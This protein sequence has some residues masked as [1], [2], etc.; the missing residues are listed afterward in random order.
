MHV[1]H[2][3]QYKMT[4]RSCSPSVTALQLQSHNQSVLI[5]KSYRA[6]SHIFSVLQEHIFCHQHQQVSQEQQLLLR[7]NMTAQNNAAN[8]AYELA[9]K[10]ARDL[11]QKLQMN[12]LDSDKKSQLVDIKTMGASL[13]ELA[14]Q[15]ADFQFSNINGN[16]NDLVTDTDPRPAVTYQ[17]LPPFLICAAGSMSRNEMCPHSDFD[18]IIIVPRIPGRVDVP[19]LQEVTN[20][21][22]RYFTAS[23][24]N[25]GMYWPFHKIDLL[26]AAGGSFTNVSFA[27]EAGASQDKN[28]P[29]MRVYHRHGD[30][31]DT[32]LAWTQLQEGLRTLDPVDGVPRL[33]RFKNI[34]EQGLGSQ[35]ENTVR[36]KF[37]PSAGG[38]G[39]LTWP[40]DVE[41]DLKVFWPMFTKMTATMAAY[42][43]E[44]PIGNLH[45]APGDFANVTLRRLLDVDYQ[46]PPRLVDAYL[47]IW[48]IR[49]RLHL[50]YGKEWDKF[51]MKSKEDATVAKIFNTRVW[52]N[53]IVGLPIVDRKLLD[54]RFPK[55]LKR[56]VPPN[57]LV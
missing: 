28:N 44:R 32:A 39:D 15:I 19:Q 3:N 24:A 9:D 22:K 41:V 7:S 16:F 26:G 11:L 54:G 56:E 46:F 36:P 57:V 49:Y 23:T 17:H 38:R 50:Q 42:N 51:S 45:R 30:A 29:D 43:G 52:P 25:G 47:G 48:E 2:A 1:G 27:F 21:M 31:A 40:E 8:R 4:V 18:M 12:I 34:L 35:Y 10:N 33:E 6:S 14:Y 53:L 37:P 5:L 20:W 55:M 13:Q